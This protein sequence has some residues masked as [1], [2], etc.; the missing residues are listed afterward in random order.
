MVSFDSSVYV[1]FNNAGQ[2]HIET[3]LSL[4][5]SNGTQ[6]WAEG[7]PLE[8]TGSLVDL[9][10]ATVQDV[11]INESTGT[12]AIRFQDGRRIDV[13]PDDD[14]E[15]WSYAGARGHKIICRPGGELLIF[16]PHDPPPT[17]S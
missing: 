17:V 2:I 5:D 9:M 6:P 4:T 3:K 10:R 13:A 11:D 12:L 16:D 14:Y 15:A 1:F 7:K 8:V